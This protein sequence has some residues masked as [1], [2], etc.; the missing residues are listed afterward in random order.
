[1][2]RDT[3]LFGARRL[4]SHQAGVGYDIMPPAVEEWAKAVGLKDTV[5]HTDLVCAPEGTTDAEAFIDAWIT[6]SNN[7]N[8]TGLRTRH[9]MG[10]RCW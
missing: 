3:D 8:S 2:E 1:M 9:R 4:L 6:E 7:P 10:L 5:L